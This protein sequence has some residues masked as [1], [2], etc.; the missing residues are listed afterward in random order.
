MEGTRCE[1]RRYFPF[2]VPGGHLG[3]EFSV[4]AHHRP[5]D[6]QHS[7]RFFPCI[8]RRCRTAGDS[9]PDAHQ[10]GLQGQTQDRDAARGDQLRDS[11]DALFGGCAGAT[12]RLLVDFQCH[13]PLDGRADRRP[14]FP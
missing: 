9:R 2:T 14:V 4:H 6:R 7:Y 1:P 12:S 11:G 8:D 13:D 5:G 3:C 10:L